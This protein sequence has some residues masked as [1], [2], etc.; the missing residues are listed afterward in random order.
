MKRLSLVLG[1]LVL[2]A[3]CPAADDTAAD[4]VGT[5][6]SNDETTEGTDTEGTDTTSDTTG[7]EPVASIEG[8]VLDTNGGTLP[9]PSLQFCGPVNEDGSVDA[10][11]PIMLGDDGS[12][13][14]GVSTVGI[15]NVKAVQGSV[16]GNHF[17]G[18][19]FQID[20]VEGAEDD[21]GT[22]SVPVVEDVTDLSGASGVTDVAIDAS[23]TISLDPAL[24]QTVSF[25]PPTELGGVLVDP[26]FW[27]ID[28][29]EGNNVLFGWT[30]APFG[31]KAT[32][33]SFGIAINDALGLDPDTT[34]KLWEIEKDNARLHQV[35]EGTVNADATGIDVTEVGEGLHELTWLIVTD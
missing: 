3:A 34:I 4:D 11:I 26:S 23:L 14:H 25:T 32:E 29:I 16:D 7:V 19:A 10:C 9:S 35:G 31:T 17:G 28:T 21:L 27:Q 22:I 8:V 1:S 30:F 33:G 6:D 18:Q 5:E 12:F 20:I 24:A 2:C 13:M 15:W